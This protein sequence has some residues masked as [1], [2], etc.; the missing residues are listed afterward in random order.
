MPSSTPAAPAIPPISPVPPIRRRSVW[1]K[2]LLIIVIL[3]LLAGGGAVGYAYWQ[4][5]G[6]FSQPPYAPEKLFAGLVESFSKLNSA[7][8]RSSLEIKTEPRE[9]DAKPFAVDFGGQ[10]FP[11]DTSIIPVPA[12]FRFASE[13]SGLFNRQTTD[14]RTSDTQAQ[15]KADLAGGDFSFSVDLEWLKKGTDF[16]VRLNKFPTFF[17]FDLGIVKGKWVKITPD[18]LVGD[19][20][21]I[22]FSQLMSDLNEEA[23]K[24]QE[25][26]AAII[27]KVLKMAGE[28]KVLT[29]KVAKRREEIN[30]QPTWRYDLAV[31]REALI[32]FYERLLIEFPDLGRSELD[33]LKSPEAEKIFA[34]LADNGQLS[35]WVSEPSGLLLAT[36]YRLRFVP[37]AGTIP[38]LTD[39]QIGLVWHSELTKHNQPT[40]V[41]P[42]T[43]FRPIKEVLTELFPGQLKKATNTR[44]KAAMSGLRAEAES[45]VI[46]AKGLYPSTLCSTL[47]KKIIEQVSTT[48]TC[49]QSNNRLSW[50]AHAV[51]EDG[52]GNFCVDSSGLA[53]SS[54][55]IRAVGGGAKAAVC[56]TYLLLH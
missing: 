51:L 50:A 27:E 16:Y 15:I 42:P 29:A 32:K 7:N 39:K 44:I 37:P 33:E 20:W 10:N 30:G 35:V 46:N 22:S 21:Q 45:V 14:W 13:A 12:D 48:I 4:K 43:D 25:K 34:Y 8:Y 28:E 17:F 54:P 6:P 36:T 3:L 49:L 52:T 24:N 5:I 53:S 19:N 23:A 40:V 18:D 31:N 26:I 1:P 56:Q 55:T 47:S 2:V 41:T 9:A 11:F 38:Q